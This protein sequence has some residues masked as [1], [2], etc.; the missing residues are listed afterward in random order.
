MVHERNVA[1]EPNL[2]SYTDQAFFVAIRSISQESII[3][4][5][6]IYEHPV[7]VDGLRRFHRNFGYGVVGRL[8]ERSPLPFGRHRWIAAPGAPMDI[9]FSETR[10]RNELMAWMDERSHL[11]VDPEWGPGWRM[12]V[13]PMTDGATAISVTVSHGLTD[14]L[15]AAARVVQALTGA[16]SDLGYPPPRSRTLWRALTEDLGQAAKDLPHQ[17]RGLYALA[18]LARQHYKQWRREESRAQ[19]ATPYSYSEKTVVLPTVF[20]SVAGSEWD[21]VAAGIGGT[22]HSLLAG[23]AAK[24]GQRLGRCS[25]DDGYV[26]LLIPIS[27]RQSLEDNRANAVAIATVKV[28]PRNVSTDLAPCRSLV[29]AAVEK[30]RGE[31]EQLLDGLAIVPWLPKHVVRGFTDAKFRLSSA[32][33]VFCSNVG[34]L[35]AEMLRID[36]TEAEYLFIRGTDR[37]VTREALEKRNG[38]LTIMAGRVGDRLLIS[39]VAYQPGWANSQEA[40]RGVVVESFR[41]FGIAVNIE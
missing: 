28:D 37:L 24:V 15:G 30:A 27:V 32:M 35:P 22:S 16:P 2:L 9:E 10:S 20:C 7:D 25:P 19:T 5:T 40:L 12:G 34:D 41:E 11:P 1:G 4:A 23:F 3:Q 14:G 26:T 6:W 29:R 13:L 38:L 36:G 18:G 39:T 8:V 31:S 17:V 21:A 33:P